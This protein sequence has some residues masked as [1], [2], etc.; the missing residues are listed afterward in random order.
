MRTTSTSCVSTAPITPAG[1]LVGTTVKPLAFSSNRSA[2]TT[3]GW[4]SATRMRGW[5]SDTRLLLVPEP[6]VGHVEGASSV[7]G[8]VCTVRHLDDGGAFGIETTEQRH[9]FRRLLGVQ[10]AGGLVGQEQAGLVDD[11]PG[12]PHQL[13]LS[14]RELGGV[15]VL[16]S[17]DP[18]PVEGVR[19]PGLDLLP[20][21]A[22][23]PERNLEVLG[24]R[25]V[26]EQVVA[27]E[28]E[29]HVA[30]GEALAVPAGHPVHPLTVELVLPAPV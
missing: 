16:L 28:H 21:K 19:H 27:L 3:S 18:E 6:A 2:S 23:V 17:D 25:Q 14:A 30:P 11:G 26:V 8:V 24:H 22:A 9:D 4:S 12:H 13:L 1:E 10:V 5:A 29:A 7:G 15:K 20:G